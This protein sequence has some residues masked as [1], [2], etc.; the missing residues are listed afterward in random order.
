MGSSPA[1]PPGTALP[2]SPGAR[3]AGIDLAR[4]LAMLGMISVHL[5][6]SA[7]AA[8]QPTL[9]HTLAY[10]N[11]SALFAVLAGVGLALSTGRERVPQGRRLRG[12]RAGVVV[13]GLAIGT[14]GLLLGTFVPFLS[15]AVILPAYGVLFVLAAPALG[16]SVTGLAVRAGLIAVLVPV[17]SHLVRAH[18]PPRALRNPTLGSLL[19]DPG[20][21]LQ[22]LLLTGNYPALAWLA[23]LCLGLAVGRALP[24]GGRGEAALVGLGVGLALL[25]RTVSVVLLD[26]N[27]GRQ[28][29]TRDVTPD[30]P[31]QTLDEILLFG[32]NG[33]LP[34]TSPWWL[35]VL[36]PHTTT[37]F[38][39]IATGGVALAVIGGALTLARLVP[40]GV[41]VLAAFGRMPLTTYAGHLMLLS[42]LPGLG[43]AAL[44]VHVIV[45]GT[46]VAAW[47]RLVH[48]R[49]PLEWSV[50][51][52]ADAAER[53]VVDVGLRHPPSA[54]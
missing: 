19:S 35:A 24:H 44:V 43:P 37:S 39:L 46:F 27:S 1:H 22:D 29:L 31:Q 25:A 48:S 2:A 7:D 23:Y 11:A 33:T 6:A 20:Q 50:R 3:L 12:A 26:G 52:L 13:R 8:G 16:S 40:R 30:L 10:G 41:G 53:C 32:A 42:L 15:A 47:G 21:T 34:T 5:L 28:K 14:I 49:G 9:V 18:L 51:R 4:L 17:L 45:L 54:S 38:D 36:A